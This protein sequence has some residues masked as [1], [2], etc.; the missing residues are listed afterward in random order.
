MCK[1][2]GTD[3][4]NKDEYIVCC[5]D[6]CGEPIYDGEKYYELNGEAI[7]G[8]CVDNM[9]SRELLDFLGYTGYTASA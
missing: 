8:D 7:C 4:Y 5:C 9:T 2:L 3:V 6:E 1:G